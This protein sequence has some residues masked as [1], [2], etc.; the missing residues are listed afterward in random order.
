MWNWIFSAGGSGLDAE[1]LFEMKAYLL[2]SLYLGGM[3]LLFGELS[4]YAIIAAQIAMF[5]AVTVICFRVW[6]T[7]GPAIQ[8]PAGVF[9]CGAFFILFGLFDAVAWVYWPLTDI[10]FLLVTALFI[11]S[12]VNGIYQG[13]RYFPLA[14]VIVLVGMVTRPTGLALF[15]IYLAT[16]ANSRIVGTASPGNFRRYAAAILTLFLPASMVVL[17][18]PWVVWLIQAGWSPPGVLHDSTLVHNLREASHLFSLGEV[19]DSRPET[20]LPSP[21]GYF[22]YLEVLLHRLYYYYWPFRETFSTKHIVVLSVYMPLTLCLVAIGLYSLA[23]R[24]L[25]EFRILLLLGNCALYF[26]LLHG[27]TL[28]AHSWRYQVPATL[29]YWLLAGFGLLHLLDRVRSRGAPGHEH[30]SVTGR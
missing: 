23:R 24:S 13:S 27:I 26:G 25:L 21:S 20:T 1:R 18:V 4:P 29:A 15:A 22:G 5:S 6:C 19:V 7:V 2:S 17:L 14:L 9:P 12:L 8:A 11:L 30:A 3:T 10:I 28:V 16:V